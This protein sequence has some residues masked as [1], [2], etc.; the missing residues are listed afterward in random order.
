MPAPQVYRG[1]SIRRW[2][3]TLVEAAGSP[4]GENGGPAGGVAGVPNAEGQ[5]PGLPT[6][7]VPMWQGA[8]RGRQG[9][10]PFHHSPVRPVIL[11]AEQL[12][13]PFFLSPKLQREG[14]SRGPGVSQ[15][16]WICAHRLPLWW[17]P[18]PLAPCRPGGSPRSLPLTWGRGL[19]GNTQTL[20]APTRPP[21][22]KLVS[23]QDTNGLPGHSCFR[24][25]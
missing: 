14:S 17:E 19:L 21:Q 15:Q 13:N 6:P 12:R 7:R 18:Q 11:T 10:T 1:D 20:W 4:H 2:L 23:P 9:C 22:Q 3:Q 16:S 5:P 8:W 24:D 25:K